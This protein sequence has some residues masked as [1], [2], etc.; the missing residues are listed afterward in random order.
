MMVSTDAVGR[1]CICPKVRVLMGLKMLAYGVSASAFV[2]YFQMSIITGQLCFKK[3]V[4]VF[5]KVIC[6]VPSSIG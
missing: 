1:C 4:S 6:Y 3:Y 5:P 2:D